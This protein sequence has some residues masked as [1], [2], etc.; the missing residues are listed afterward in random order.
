MVKIRK[1]I[2]TQVRQKKRRKNKNSNIISDTWRVRKASRKNDVWP[3]L[4]EGE[5]TMKE[6]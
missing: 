5:E 2:G 1:G 6:H 3:N 4:G